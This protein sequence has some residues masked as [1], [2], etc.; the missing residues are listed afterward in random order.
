[1]ARPRK[2]KSALSDNNLELIDVSPLTPNQQKFFSNYDSGKSQF[3]LGYPGTGKSFMSLFKA[4]EEV[5]QANDYKRV[6][7]I[8]S[9][10]PTR[11]IGHL[12][13]SDVEKAAIYELPYKKI[14]SELFHRDD[15]YEVLKKHDGIRFMTTSFIRGLTLDNS[16]V[17][18]DEFQ[19]MSS[20]ELDSIITR[21]G[22]SSKIIFCGD[23][24]QTDLTR[25]SEKKG[26]H[27][28]FKV[29]SQMLN[30]FDLNHFEEQD[31]V[32]SHLVK[33]YIIKKYKLFTEGF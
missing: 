23:F 20:H 30:F 16:I 4:F 10:V 27:K 18:V 31:I 3:L 14:C 33:D 15:A 25:E 5:S 21:I 1:M 22:S 9:A 12:P 13:G 24:M 6:V 11:D 17:I 32:R 26:A 2:H 19:S 29:V 28:F 8:R 7:I